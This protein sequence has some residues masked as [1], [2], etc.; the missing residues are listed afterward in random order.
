M[1][2]SRTRR[3]AGEICRGSQECNECAASEASAD[4]EGQWL[5]RVEEKAAEYVRR[6]NS[7]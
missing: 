4:M 6:E 7:L 5:V 1:L 3:D 2:P